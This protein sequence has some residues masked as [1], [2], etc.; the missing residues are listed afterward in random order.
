VLAFQGQVLHARRRRART[1]MGA[2]G[3][4][5][6]KQ[7]PSLVSV[8]ALQVGDDGRLRWVIAKASSLTSGTSPGRG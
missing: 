6:V 4:A 2:M 8:H 1:A 7:L 3:H 5:N